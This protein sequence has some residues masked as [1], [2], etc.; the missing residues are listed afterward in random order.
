[1]FYFRFGFCITLWILSG[2]LATPLLGGNVST[3]LENP[4]RFTETVRNT[5]VNSVKTNPNLLEEQFNALW[6]FY[7][8]TNGATWTWQ[9]VTS[10]AQIWNFTELK[11]NPCY[12]HWQGITC[13]CQLQYCVLTELQLPLYGL[14]GSLPSSIGVWSSLYLINLRVNHLSGTIPNTIRNWTMLSQMSLDFNHLKGIIPSEIGFL[15]DLALL[16]L[17]DNRLTGSMP[18]SIGNATQLTVIILDFNN[19]NG[20]IPSTVGNLKSLQFLSVGNNLLTGSVP[21]SIGNLTKLNTLVLAY[22]NFSHSLPGEVGDLFELTGLDL[23]GNSF[24]GSLPSS[25]GNL[26]NLIELRIAFNQ[27]YGSLPSS[28][29]ELK[30]LEFLYLNE[31]SFTGTVPISI[32]NLKNLTELD[33]SVNKLVGTLPNIFENL[34]RLFLLFLNENM[35]SGTIPSSVA[36]LTRLLEFYLYSNNFYGG[37]KVF[38]E[39]VNLVYFDLSSNYFDGKCDNLLNNSTSLEEAGFSANLFSGSLPIYTSSKLR[40][41]LLYNMSINYFTGSISS[42]FSALSR[43]RLFAV[44]A[45]YLSGTIPNIFFTAELQDLVVFNVSDNLLTGSFLSEYNET[46]YPSQLQ[47]IMLDSNFLTGTLPSHLSTFADTIVVFSFNDNEFS[48]TIP[49]EYQQFVA[50]KEFFAQNNNLKG[51]ITVLLNS[52]IP[53]SVVNIDLSNNQFTGLM[54]TSFFLNNNNLSTFA[55]VAN[56]LSGSVPDNICNAQSLTALALDGI[57]TAEKCRDYILPDT[58]FDGF[59]PKYFLEGTVPVCLFSLPSLQSLHLSGNGLTGSF[60]DSLNISNSLE[61]LSL[62]H[63]VI[64]GTIPDYIQRHSWSKLDLSYNKLTGT[65][66]TSFMLPESTSLSLQVNRLS[67][68]VPSKLK[69]LESIN[70]LDGNIFGCNSNNELPEHDPTTATYSCGSNSTDY[71]LFAWVFL[72]GF[73][74][75]TITLKSFCGTHSP[76]MK[77]FIDKLHFEKRFLRDAVVANTRFHPRN[78]QQCQEKNDKEK[79]SEK[80]RGFIEMITVYHSAFLQFAANNP[81]SNLAMFWELLDIIKKGFATFGCISILFLLPLYITATVFTHSYSNEYVWIVSAILMSGEQSALILFFAFL[82]LVGAYLFIFIRP[83]PPLERQFNNSEIYPM[84]EGITK[85]TTIVTSGRSTLQVAH[86]RIIVLFLDVLLFGLADIGYVLIVINFNSTTIAFA[87]FGL[88]GVK[89][90]ANNVILWKAIPSVWRLIERC[91]CRFVLDELAEDRSTSIRQP[92]HFTVADIAFLER[93]TLLNNIILPILAILVILPD[94]FYNALFTAPAVSSSYSYINCGNYIYL[95]GSQPDI[96]QQC[97]SVDQQTSY[98][99]PFIYSYQCSSKILINYAPVY[100]V[101]FIYIGFLRP[102]RMVV[103]KYCYDYSIKHYGTTSKLFRVS[104]ALLP[105]ILKNVEKERTDSEKV[106]YSKLSLTTQL[107][108][109][110][111]II[112]V[113]GGLFPPLAVIGC[114]S[115]IIMTYCEQLLI[116]RVLYESSRLGCSFYKDKLEADCKDIKPLVNL[117]FRSTLVIMCLFFAYLLFDTWGDEKG[118]ISALPVTCIMVVMPLILLLTYKPF[119]RPRTKTPTIQE[120]LETGYSKKSEDNQ[121]SKIV[122]SATPQIELTVVTNPLA[123]EIDEC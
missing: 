84:G 64:T 99:P 44:D 102:L 70:I 89:L 35:L 30:A 106:L 119:Y 76:K 81:G 118:A 26:H 75:L 114:I 109:Y 86:M 28:L 43:L 104:D 11:P 13:S 107:S 59:Y 65:L 54:S 12:D 85:Q 60:P 80:E 95:Y 1:M 56:C 5:I 20:S 96:I 116:G 6:E 74:V 50:L 97:N 41:F 67:G 120:S 10:T 108:S 100:I 36:S 66:S 122:E 57:S 71:F 40:S 78:D 24:T 123:K 92:Y 113:F 93:L 32:S 79:E 105:R 69:G 22:N 9:T 46:L 25:I 110:L 112:I 16:N 45:N 17:Y 53:K 94:C 8:S 31:N 15:S 51:S 68:S 115:V 121:D 62:S 111:A 19:L 88:S 58:N 91:P 37:T 38:Y 7:N 61:Y 83:R 34:E 27:F 14:D 73:A 117:T 101:K 2:T 63:N 42:N 4:I 47:E 3:L 98:F 90:L 103:L 52:T 77:P 82:C 49:N 33:L 72:V 48:G 87:T 23:N 55:A 21:S 18:S 29:G 39:L